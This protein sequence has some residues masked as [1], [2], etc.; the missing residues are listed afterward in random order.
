MTNRIYALLVGI[1]DYPQNVGKLS[2]CL[3]DVDHFNAYLEDN[4][5]QAAL[6]IEVL[7]DG[8]ATRGNIIE[9]FRKHLGKA[10]EGDVAVF[11]YCGHGARWASAAAFKEFYPDGK[12]EGLVCI[13][14]RSPG[15]FDLADKELAVLI[16]EVAKNN[17]HLAVILDCC[18]SGSGTRAIENTPRL[19]PRL[20]EEVITERPLESYLDGYYAGL[21]ELFV[22]SSKHV[23]LAA[24]KRTQLAQEDLRDQSGIFTT[25]LLEV[26]NKSGDDLTYAELFVQCRAAVRS[27]ASNQEPQFEAYKHFNSYSGFLG[28]EVS[29]RGPRYVVKHDQGG[30]KVE[31]GAIHGVPTE[32]EKTVTLALYP[33]DD[34]ARLAGT[35]STIQVGAQESEVELDFSSDE[36]M[37][38]RAEITSMPV[39][40]MAIYFQGDTGENASLQS[41][42]EK[43]KSVNVELTDIEAAARYAFSVQDGYLQLKRLEDELLVQRTEIVENKLDAAAGLLLPFL[44]QI[45]QWERGLALQ[46]PGTKL[47]LALVDFRFDQR[48][49]TGEDV[50]S[51]EQE[52]FLDYVKDES[53]WKNIRGKIKACNRT[54]QS[55]H[56]LLA[57]YSPAY[58]VYILKNDPIDPGDDFVTLWGDEPN[59]YFHLEDGDN[60]SRENFKLIVSTEKIDNFLLELDDM[61][62]GGTPSVSRA[63]GN[64][65]TV[66]KVRHQNEWFT[67][68]LRIRLVRRLDQARNNDSNG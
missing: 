23:L 38:Y 51:E 30:W 58:G 64:T 22:P 33:Q 17:P 31:C 43:D 7:K 18:H 20:T 55:L 32:P 37:R 60:E 28:N 4:Y 8:D 5:D 21:Q 13:D 41:A 45:R 50:S 14:S 48:S 46:N 53:G 54:Q 27:R 16:A 35:A 40:P 59:D 11:Q 66:K 42:L 57:Y 39:P 10:R 26:L 63:I 12:D 29:S 62:L 56:M 49:G 67:K 65:K 1:N 36:S 24:C 47:D 2:G 61:E 34:K 15:G 6:A 52:I 9:Q 19:K 68:D 25:T 3:N 44:K